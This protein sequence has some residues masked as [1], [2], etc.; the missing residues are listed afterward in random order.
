MSD[1]LATGCVG[2]TVEH[3]DKTTYSV[4]CTT[5]G[6]EVYTYHCIDVKLDP[7]LQTRINRA[8]ERHVQRKGTLTRN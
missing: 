2:Q 3:G 4:V 5:C 8:W 7:L 1:P 6:E